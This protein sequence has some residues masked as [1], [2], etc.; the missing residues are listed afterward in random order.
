MYLDDG[1]SYTYRDGKSI[2]VKMTYDN[3]N[4][5]AK[6]VDPVGAETKV[7]LEKVVIQGVKS[8]SG[9]C[10]V[11]GADGEATVEATYDNNKGVLVVRKP[12]VNM[13]TEW[14]IQC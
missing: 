1:K 8:R 6:L 9:E 10:K 3:G 13:A 7:W 12:A 2:Y 11:K 5:Q 4:I 14:T